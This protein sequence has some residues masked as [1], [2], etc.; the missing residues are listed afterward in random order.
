MP[1]RA[2]GIL[3]HPTS[4]P[5]PF[6]I[7]DLGP[8]AY[9]FIDFLVESGQRIWQILPLGPTGHGN[10]PYASYSAMA[11]NALLISPQILQEKGLLSHQDIAKPPQFPKDSVDYDRVINYKINL[12]WKAFENFQNQPQE[13]FKTFCQHHET[14]LEDYALFMAIKQMNRGKN[15]N[16]WNPALRDREP[17]AL[18]ACRMLL[19]VEINFIKYQQFEFFRQWGY[20]K[21]YTNDRKIQILGDLPIYVAH[22]SADVWAHPENFCLHPQ[23]GN[24]TLM[25]GVPPDY[26]SATG[27]LWGNPIYNWYQLRQKNYQWWVERF[28]AMLET[29]DWIRIDHFRAFESYWV[30][31][32]GESTAMNGRWIKGPSEGFF[33][34]IEEQLGRLPVVAEDLGIITPEVEALRDKFHLP[35]M[36]IL[37][38]AFASGWGNAYLPHNYPRNCVAYTGTHD[39]DTTLGWLSD[40]PD[41]EK[42][43]FLNYLGQYNLSE[44]HWDAIRVITSSVAD[45]AIIPLQDVLGIGREGRM[46]TPGI[47]E[48]N[49]GWRYTPGV[50]T[51]NLSSRLRNL[52]E[53]YGRFY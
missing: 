20:L 52:A 28:Q 14:W 51:K 8:E 41:F 38:F 48:G 3:L 15:W 29:V 46:N 33:Q 34:S 35:G 32:Q 5:S 40:L 42:N 49:W 21:R 9:K 13:E 27:Q 26:F 50:L 1:H 4:L 11:G 19:E 44:I 31:K 10:S 47:G 45:W 18:K 53:I 16:G 23:T 7:G 30:V 22:D 12:F 24:S 39:N 2:S 6:G 25:A 43:N 17:E 36:K 37:H